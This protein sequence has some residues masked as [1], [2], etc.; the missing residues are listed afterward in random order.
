MTE[1]WKGHLFG[2]RSETC[3]YKLQA[4]DLCLRFILTIMA[5]HLH[6]CHAMS[7]QCGTAGAN[8]RQL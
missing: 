8:L 3:Q 5:G 4:S 2:I 6:V 1:F 7:A